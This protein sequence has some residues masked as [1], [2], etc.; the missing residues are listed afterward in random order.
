[1]A[2]KSILREV[3][4]P[5]MMKALRPAPTVDATTVYVSA[6]ATIAAAQAAGLSVCDYVE[7]LWGESGNSASLI[8]RL[9]SLGA[10][11]S[12]TK[13]VVEI[14]PGTGRY[15]EHT[16]KHCRPNCYQIYETDS[17]WSSWLVKHYPIQV[18]A[19]DGRSLKSTDSNSSEL[20][21]AHGVFVY[22]P[23]MISYRYFKEI[24][25][26]AAPGAFVAFD[27]ISERCLDSKTVEKWIESGHD[28]P[29][30]L[31]SPYVMQF[32]ETCGFCLVDRFLWPLDVGWSEYLILRRIAA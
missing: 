11:S 31:S 28:F 27:I 1:M 12:A 17:G 21:H 15:I 32:F 7:R 14:G 8:D 29:C 22:L 6:P 13:N 3:V 16:L 20:I 18:C 23:F 25:R 9:H 4:P 26:V 5:I 30:F 24:A 19:A 10:I 2:W